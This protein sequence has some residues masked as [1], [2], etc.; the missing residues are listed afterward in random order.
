MA[1]ERIKKQ[2]TLLIALIPVIL[3]VVILI[4]SV[5]VF[6]VDVQVPLIIGTCITAIIAIGALGFTWAE[7]EEGAI[8]SVKSVMQAILLLIVIG[9]TIGTWIAGGIVTSLVYYGL[10]L[11]S[12]GLF[13]IISMVLCSVVSIAAGGSWATVGTIGIALIGIAHGLNIPAGLAAG[14]IL[15]GAYF[16]D[17]M[18]PLSDTTNLAAAVSGANLM[19]HIKNMMYTTIP[20]YGISLVLFGV[21][22]ARY[23]SQPMD[24]AQINGILDALASSY[25]LS[26]ALLLV[27]VIVIVIVAMKVPAIP[28][29]FAG[30]VLGLLCSVFVQRLDWSTVLNSLMYGVVSETGHEMVDGLLTNGGFMNMMWVISLII[31]A[32]SFGGVLETA[33]MME[34]IA[35]SLLKFAHKTGSLVLVTVITGLFCNVLLGDHCIAIAIPGRMYKEEY[36][37]RGLAPRVL[38]RVLEDAGTVTSPLIPW[39][40]CGAT[41]AGFLGISTL[42][43]A[44]FAFFCILCPIITVI[45][46][47]TGFG[48]M[49]LENDPAAKEYV[50]PAKKHSGAAT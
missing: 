22:G 42:T 30:T 29:L 46:G 11:L 28:G 25:T 35:R 26:P 47:F 44:P 48:V 16:G 10:Q 34:V 31:C 5:S 40:T 32:L 6:H 17:K 36:H 37:R 15:S 13:L 43:Y 49:K 3:T 20:A 18:S 41:M 45:S 27:P 39:N 4:L 9:A 1:K 23:A 12:P 14:A 2:P 24:A 8:E 50:G 21:I 33:G 19:D 38:S 7:L